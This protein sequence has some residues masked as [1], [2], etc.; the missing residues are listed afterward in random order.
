MHS[1]IQADLANPLHAEAEISLLDAYASDPMGGGKGL[2]DAVKRNLCTQ[3]IQR[4]AVVVLAFDDDKPV[5]LIN[6]FEAFSTFQ[7]KPILNIHDVA[8]L[9]AHRGQGIASAMLGKVAEIARQ[10]GCCKLTLEVLEHN[11]P[12]RAIYDK[13]GFRGYELVP[14]AGQALFLEKKL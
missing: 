8:V 11:A 6:A 1:I 4:H 3:L 13:F 12:A 14:A 9:P 7:C 10:R 5:G 2:S